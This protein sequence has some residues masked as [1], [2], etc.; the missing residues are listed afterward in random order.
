MIFIISCLACWRICHFIVKENGP[1]DLMWDARY[2]LQV[3]AHFNPVARFFYGL[4]SCVECLSVWISLMIAI[5]VFQDRFMAY[6][7]LSISSVTM[8]IEGAY[9]LLWTSGHP[10]K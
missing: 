8:L 6:Y 1:N 9:E 5:A 7:W 3:S 10:Q 4:V 2:D